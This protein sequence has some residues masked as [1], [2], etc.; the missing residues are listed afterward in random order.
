M[1]LQRDIPLKLW[2]WAAAGE[3]V[4]LAFN[5]GEY[6]TVADSEGKWLITIPAQKQGGPYSITFTGN[7]KVTV[8]N[9]L[10]GDVWLCG[11]QSNM[12]L[13]MDRVRYKYP[14]VV[15]SANNPFIRQF[16]VQ[17]AWDFKAPKEDVAE[18][19]WLT[20][21]PANILKFSAVAYFFADEI[22]RRYKVPIGL[23][24]AALGG[25][26]AESWISE[27]ALKKFP[28]QYSE[29][30]KYRNDAL[31]KQIEWNDR[32][33]QSDWYTKANEL[34]EGL[35]YN[36]KSSSIVDS[37]WK[38]M[39][40]PGYWDRGPLGKT[41]GI[42][43]F[44]KQVEVSKAFAGKA[45]ELVLGRIVD[46]DSVFVNGRFVGTTTYQ[47]P[48]RRYVVPAGFLQEGENFIVVRVVSNS[49]SGGFVED[50]PYQLITAGDTIDLKG[51]WKYNL[52]AK[53][54]PLPGQTFIR[55]KPLGLYNAMIAPLTN[56]GI[57]GVLWYQGESNAGNPSNYKAL[58]ATL[59]SDWRMKWR[60]GNFPFL[61]VQLPNFMEAKTNPSE[62]GWAALREAQLQMLSVPN[63]AMA[64]AIDIGEWNDVHPLNKKDVGHRL[65]L[66]ARKV[67][68]GEKDITA[69]GPIFKAIERKGN[70]LV[71][72]FSNAVHGLISRDNKQLKEFAIAG[73][74]KNFVWAK[75]A[76]RGNKVIV[77]NDSVSHPVTVRYAWADNPAGANL[78][79]KDGLPASPFQASIGD[80]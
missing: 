13:T 69:S 9:I 79:N 29:A 53:M 46:A 39:Q 16:E 31:V 38:Q 64:V 44:R 61:Y 2:G 12:E 60:E 1:I 15:A 40:I 74:D 11:G 30:I 20:A 17:D 56:Y 54:E 42:V 28:Q 66:Q 55:W 10:F 47:Y 26:P 76:I 75:A 32:K 4:R 37:S 72:T 8:H 49:G 71:I 80:H 73:S 27:E 33:V 58:M 19:Q 77:W 18:G 45:T 24:N 41:N 25:S 78:Y 67:A 43:W 57:K 62:S 65:A 34:D 52:G 36:W 59:I 7:N 48:P 63:T 22:Y 5:S 23:I 21:T 35:R 51:N 70:G 68:Y 6:K 14:V 50:K 3:K